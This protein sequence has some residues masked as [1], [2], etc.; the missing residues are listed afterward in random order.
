MIRIDLI[1][2]DYRL[3]LARRQLLIRYGVLTL[4]SII[5]C[6]GAHQYLRAQVAEMSSRAD[7][8]RAQ[9]EITRQQ[10]ADVADL[11]ARQEEYRR[12]L[13]V[14]QGLRA[15]AEVADI[16]AIVDR[17]I[18]PGRLWFNDWG[19]RRAGVAADEEARGVETG[20]F[21]VV[22]NGSSG[23]GVE[24]E[25]HMSIRGQA[26]D[27]QA[28]STFIRNLFSESLVKDVNLHRTSISDYANG[29]VVNFDVTVV[30][31]S[32]EQRS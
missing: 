26:R 20:Y 8:L 32:V 9:N 23:D 22:A 6:L 30:L 18:V 24:I 31:A 19:F 28:L 21:I 5:A 15:G 29:Q 25:T 16:F 12:Q 14:L 10:E 7:A 17:S 2:E 11:L 1:P 3:G 4:V 27:H 13:A